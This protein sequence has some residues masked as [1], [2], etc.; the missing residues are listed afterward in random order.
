MRFVF[1]LFLLAVLACGGWLAWALMQPVTPA[2]QTFVL[3]HPGYSSRRIAK[4][5]QS[6]G[7]IRS[8]DAFVLW[9][10]LRHR[11]SLKAGE[12][13]FEK[14]ATSI[15]VHRR[16][17]HGD[18]FF[19]TVVIPEG[20]NMFDIAQAI[21]NAGLGSSEDFLKVAMSDTA[22]ISDLPPDATPLQGH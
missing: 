11:R 4:E 21:Q 16:L 17:A 10:Y 3:L 19:H 8:A 5:L 15:D 18:V 13:L 2:G 6:A 14:S 12:Y 7:V 22:L 9:H 20:F 1:I